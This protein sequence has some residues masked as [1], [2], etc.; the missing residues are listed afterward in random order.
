MHVIILLY[1]FRVTLGDEDVKL[2]EAVDNVLDN[3]LSR[4]NTTT[5]KGV[6]TCRQVVSPS[7]PDFHLGLSSSE[8]VPSYSRATV[9]QYN[10]SRPSTSS[11]SQGNV[12]CW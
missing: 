12:S 10:E 3:V 11:G 5:A 1:C 8:N 7:G 9:S 2:E 4:T 6:R